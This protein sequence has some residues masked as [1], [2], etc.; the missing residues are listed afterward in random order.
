MEYA[1]QPIEEFLAGIASSNVTPAGGTAAAVVG[2]IGTS[3]CEMACI[4]T[5]GKRGYD[6]G[7]M[8]LS[9]VREELERRRGFLLELADRDSQVVTELLDSSHGGSKQTA[10]KKATGVPITVADVCSNVLEDAVVITENADANV[11]PDAGT[12]SYLVYSALKA[13][14]LT[15][16][17]N[18]ATLE[19]TQSVDEMRHRATEIERSADETFARVRENVRPER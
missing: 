11:V 4:H 8:D 2:A 10:L 6:D 1:Q 14:V 16:Q 17:T 13:S 19:E 18:V 9:E 5:I 3:L 7:E 12:G 15:A